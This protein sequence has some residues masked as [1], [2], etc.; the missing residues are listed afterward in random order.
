M[1]KN[2]NSYASVKYDYNDFRKRFTVMCGLGVRLEYAAILNALERLKRKPEDIYFEYAEPLQQA[3]MF[4]EGYLARELLMRNKGF[5][6][7]F[8]GQICYD[9]HGRDILHSR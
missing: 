2:Y 4:I 6:Y 8:N 1:K 7:D 5:Y 9:S 3:Q